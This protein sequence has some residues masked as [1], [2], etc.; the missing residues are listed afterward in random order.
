MRATVIILLL[1]CTTG[2]VPAQD[3]TWLVR[4]DESS[5]GV[6]G[7]TLEM[8]VSLAWKHTTEDE[9]SSP[10]ATP[11][12]GDDLV[13]APVGDS[14]YAI[15]RTTGELVWK[16]ATGGEIYSSPALVDG[17]LYFGSRDGNLWALD[18]EDGSVEWRYPAGGPVDCAPVIAYGVCYFG[19]DANRLIALDLETRTPRWQ[20]EAGGDIKAPPLVYRDVI[21]FGALDRRVYCLNSQGQLI[22][23]RGVERK[24]F[25]GSPVGER[26]KVIYAS[27]RK[28]E[29]RDI[30]TGRTTWPQPF[31]AADLIVGSPCV[32]GRNVYVGTSAGAIYCLDANRGR[33][34]WRWPQEGVAEPIT[35]SPVIV[36]DMIVF[37]SGQRDLIAL[38]LDGREVR[39]R[40]T[41][42]KPPEKAQAPTGP[43]GMGPGVMEPGMMPAEPGMMQEPPRAGGAGGGVA[44][45]G[46][47][48]PG[49]T[50]T[51][52][53]ER[54][55]KFEEEIDPS[56]A[57]VDGALYTIGADNV[58]Y[59]F[60]SRAPDNV[61]PMFSDPV[62]EVPG[63]QRT[64]VQ[65]LPSMATED[66]FPD[67]Y[68]DEIKIP[69]S[70]P[71]FLSLM[72]TD[73]G[74]GINP[75]LVRVSIN[76]ELA[77]FTYDASE[78]LVW[79]IYDPRGAAA[80]LSNGVKEIL[81]EATDWRGNHGARVI[82]MTIDNRLEPPEPP[83]PQT[84]AFEGP[85]MF[86]PGMEPGMAPPEGFIEPGMP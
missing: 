55:I 46:E 29:A 22:W 63:K 18:A 24:A 7:A 69:G 47:I 50:T 64:R 83:R 26:T 39:W 53:Q 15:D 51:R 75:D 66:D 27:G 23:S 25:F 76:G 61:P 52:T 82:S 5:T 9:D 85:G 31:Q 12:V 44:P 84:P 42:P 57:V 86:E 32:Q 38:S 54:E 70:P 17:I 19:S 68:A 80:N 34:V 21:V 81:F 40:Y 35:S 1:A 11:A 36:E 43:G 13:F 14:I 33:A 37:K 6:S 59:G 45:G 3:A 73:E 78:G 67:R 58:I 10:V 16:Q 41:L 49:G 65:F 79:Y 77:D 8:P 2:A 56:V 62:L 30:Y 60:E 71:I 72:L 74:S 4:Y 48:G 28:L 20:F